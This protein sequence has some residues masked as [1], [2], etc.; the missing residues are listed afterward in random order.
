ML[1]D[2]QTAHPNQ[3]KLERLEAYESNPALVPHFLASALLLP[4][5]RGFICRP[6]CLRSS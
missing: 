3:N 1:A 4:V 5:V 2:A 6:L